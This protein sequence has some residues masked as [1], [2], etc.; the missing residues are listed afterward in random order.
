MKK[1][2]YTCD[3]CGKKLPSYEPEKI[4]LPVY[5]GYKQDEIRSKID[6]NRIIIKEYMLCS[7][8]QCAIAK[9]LLDLNIIG[10]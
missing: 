8:C 7:D 9:E 3:I 4:I 6:Y 10:I 5:W 2:I 1:I